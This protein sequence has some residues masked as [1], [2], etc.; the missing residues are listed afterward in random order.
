MWP[1][2]SPELLGSFK[3]FVIMWIRVEPLW[4]THSR[5]LETFLSFGRH[6]LVGFCTCTLRCSQNSGGSLWPVF[7][8]FRALLK[9]KTFLLLRHSRAVE[10]KAML[11]I[12]PHVGITADDDKNSKGGMAISS[13]PQDRASRVHTFSFC[14]TGRAR[15]CVPCH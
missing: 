11:Y 13:S 2:V 7:C 9:N 8:F 1:C 3:T 10:V 6:V 5:L 4:R 14:L 15:P 12:A